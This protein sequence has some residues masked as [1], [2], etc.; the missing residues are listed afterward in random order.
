MGD[1]DAINSSVAS[2]MTSSVTSSAVYRQCSCSS[3]KQL[4]SFPSETV[5]VQCPRCRATINT[6]SPPRP[7]S[8]IQRQLTSRHCSSC[9]MRLL[10]SHSSTSIQCPRCMHTTDDSQKATDTITVAPEQQQQLISSGS[11]GA[12]DDHTAPT[13]RLEVIEQRE[14]DATQHTAQQAQQQDDTLATLQQRYERKLGLTS[15]QLHPADVQKEQPDS[16][17]LPVLKE[18]MAW[19]SQVGTRLQSMIALEERKAACSK[20][21]C[22]VCIEREIDVQLMPC[23]HLVV[24]SE[25]GSRVTTCPLCRVAI[26]SMAQLLIG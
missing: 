8:P 22:K 26:V 7:P 6:L 10:H 19:H 2:T 21:T 13:A 20:W 14:T 4:L 18:A 11:A 3:C 9:H 17:P 15:Q 12:S 5:W 16:L 1:D 24:C 23:R 25:C